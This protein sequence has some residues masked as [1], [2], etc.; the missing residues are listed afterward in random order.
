M[1]TRFTV[2][3]HMELLPRRISAQ[4]AILALTVLQTRAPKLR[5]DVPTGLKG[6][7]DGLMEEAGDHLQTLQAQQARQGIDVD[8]EIVEHDLPLPEALQ[9]LAPEA[10]LRA[11]T[12]V[13]HLLDSWVGALGNLLE[14]NAIQPGQRGADARALLAGWFSEGRGFL[15]ASHRLQ[16]LEIQD[17]WGT[18]QPDDQARLARLGLT[19]HVQ[20]VVALNAWFGQILHLTRDAPSPAPAAPEIDPL[21]DALRVLTR[22]LHFANLAWPGDAPE[23][24]ALRQRLAGPYIEEVQ[25][26]SARAAERA[27]KRYE[28]EPA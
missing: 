7:F 15:S 17:R 10:T 21:P 22:T 26:V 20:T 25:R 16:W 18:L 12:G 1:D 6:A 23:A 5:D 3:A 13:N 27:R 24:V 19:E 2:T 8:G 28:P 14:G 4:A 11:A 9:A